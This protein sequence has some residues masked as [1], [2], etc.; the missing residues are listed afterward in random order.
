MALS[1]ANT[2]VPVNSIKPDPESNSEPPLLLTNQDPH[3]VLSH[4]YHTR[5]SHQHLVRI[6][7]EINEHVEECQ[8]LKS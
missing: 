5:T 2:S 1:L 7:W 6:P 8:I 4:W 3:Q